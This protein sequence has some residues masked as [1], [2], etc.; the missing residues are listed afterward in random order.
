MPGLNAPFS[1]PVAKFRHYR[2]DESDV[3]A[4]PKIR[5]VSVDRHD[6]STT[7]RYDESCVLDRE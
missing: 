7:A 6:H 4:R 1:I 2:C 3:I 5:Q